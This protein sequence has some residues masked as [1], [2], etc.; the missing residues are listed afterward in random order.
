M[1]DQLC[2]SNLKGL[3]NLRH[4]PP[5]TETGWADSLG[6][7]SSSPWQ[8]WPPIASFSTSDSPFSNFQSDHSPSE[9]LLPSLDVSVPLVKQLLLTSG[10]HPDLQTRRIFQSSS[11]TLFTQKFILHHVIFKRAQLNTFWLGGNLPFALCTVHRHWDPE[12]ICFFSLHT[13]ELD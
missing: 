1:R 13:R 9:S 4:P 7:W 2:E 6:T 5:Q 11:N 12:N 10:H 3:A 8:C